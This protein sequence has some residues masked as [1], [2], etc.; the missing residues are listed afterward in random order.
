MRHLRPCRRR[1]GRWPG[2]RAMELPSN[3]SHPHVFTASQQSCV[4]DRGL[5]PVTG[6]GVAEREYSSLEPLED[7]TLLAALQICRRSRRTIHARFGRPDRECNCP[8]WTLRLL[9]NSPIPTATATSNVTLT[10]AASTT[11]KPG[12]NLDI[13]SNG[14]VAKQRHRERRGRT[15]GSPTRAGRSAPPFPSR[16]CRPMHP[17]QTGDPVTVQFALHSTSRRF[18]SNNAT[19][20]FTYSASYTYMGTTT[21]AGVQATTSWAAAGSRRLGPARSI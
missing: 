6:R 14:S 7:R 16:S 9:S 1:C 11:G 2:K 17:R 21:T 12:V 8:M 19:A 18:A 15:R 4:A 20:A 10:T 13:L 3:R 5:G